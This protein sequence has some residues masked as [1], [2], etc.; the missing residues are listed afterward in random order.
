M[1]SIGGNCL[2]GVKRSCRNVNG[3]T[4]IE[5]LVVIAIIAILAGLMLPALARAKASARQSACLNNL[6]Q[7]GLGIH[8]YAADNHDTLPSAPNL[9]GDDLATNHAA[10]FYKRL[11]KSYLGL[12]GASSPQDRVFACPADTFFYHFP[13]LTYVAESLHDQPDSDYS[14]YGF[15]GGNGFTNALPPAFLD[16]VSWP[17]VCGCKLASIV[18]PV[19]TAVVADMS[20]LFPWSWHQPQMLP[21]GNY[22]VKDARNIVSFADGHVRYIKIYWNAAYS[23]TSCCYNPPGGYDY[24]WS[25]N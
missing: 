14:S 8:L 20:A 11:V 2:I 9:T 18:D 12:S 10:V 1:S 24:K 4:L 21:P 19:R 23:L 16:E 3:F 25:A 15:M 22:G 17:G 7:V 5:L 13:S 6:R